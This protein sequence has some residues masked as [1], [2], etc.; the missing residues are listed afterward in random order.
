MSPQAHVPRP[1]PPPKRLSRR[2]WLT[3]TAAVVL[4]AVVAF[5]VW[6]IGIRDPPPGPLDEDTGEWV[7]IGKPAGV[8][9]GYGQAV[10]YN[11][12][13]RKVVLERISLIDPTPGLE[14]LSASV[15]GADRRSFSQATWTE[16]PADVDDIH[17]VAGFE[18]TPVDQPGGERGVELIFQLRADRPGDY[19]SSGITIDYTVDGDDRRS[20]IRS[21]LGACITESGRRC[22]APTP[23]GFS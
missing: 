3:G 13:T 10:I 12:S 16:R 9:W 17:A 5:G 14:V 20:V 19:T 1:L 23:P 15:A 18:V 6:R 7:G 11:R 8:E 22:K 21:G 2:Q 4:A